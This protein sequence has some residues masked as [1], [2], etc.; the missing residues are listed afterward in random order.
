VFQPELTTVE[1]ILV[2]RSCI[3]G[4]VSLVP[5][6]AG[7]WSWGA[8]PTA[9]WWSVFAWSVIV[10][11]SSRWARWMRWRRQLLAGELAVAVLVEF[12]ERAVAEGEA[13]DP[14]LRHRAGGLVMVRCGPGLLPVVGRLPD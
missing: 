7:W 9:A 10:T 14:D 1:L 8:M 13:R 2:W 6:I 11:P 4:T 12:F 5:F 3:L